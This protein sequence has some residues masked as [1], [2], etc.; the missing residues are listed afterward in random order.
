MPFSPV[1]FSAY[2]RDLADA[3]YG[4][5]R[6]Q[7]QMSIDRLRAK[8]QQAAGVAPR[9]MADIEA[10]ADALIAEESEIKRQK[11]E[12]FAPHREVL[13]E[14]RTELQAVKDALNLM[15]NGGPPLDDD[16][17]NV[18]PLPLVRGYPQ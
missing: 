13:A 6:E 11:D 17:P 3:V 1:R 2:A 5:S 18:T 4:L 10:E 14:S 9:V 12:A 7:R 8:L 16:E 15:S